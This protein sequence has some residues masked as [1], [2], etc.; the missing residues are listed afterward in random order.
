MA[1]VGNMDNMEDTTD[2]MVHKLVVYKDTCHT[3]NKG[4]ILFPYL[5]RHYSLFLIQFP[6]P[7]PFYV[8]Q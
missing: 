2:S 6:F 5:L 7:S 1:E 3:G 4:S 8:R